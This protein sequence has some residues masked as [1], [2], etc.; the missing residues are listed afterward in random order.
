M[1]AKR[2]S[3]ITL[4]LLIA[5]AV[6]L[7]TSIVL[8]RPACSA[9]AGMQEGLETPCSAVP[10]QDNAQGKAQVQPIE[11]EPELTLVAVTMPAVDSGVS[12]VPAGLAY[13]PAG[14]QLL[15]AM[16]ADAPI[17]WNAA[18]GE[19]VLELEGHSATARTTV[20][21]P[22][23]SLIAGGSDDGTV[24]LWDAETG[25]VL[26]KLDAGFILVNGLAFSPDSRRVA[27]TS[28]IDNTLRVWDVATGELLSNVAL[29]RD[30]NFVAWSPDSAQVAVSSMADD[31]G[32]RVFVV[33]ADSG[34]LV[35][36]LM[37]P[38]SNTAGLSYSPDGTRLISAGFQGQIAQ[39]WDAATG[40]PLLTL[41]GHT[42]PVVFATYNPDGTL[43]ATSAWDGARL[44]DAATGE[45]RLA[46]AAPGGIAR[47]IFSPD[48]VHLATIQLDGKARIYNLQELL[49]Q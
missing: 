10:S 33:D 24:I 16:L 3:R 30:L 29:D 31:E 26:H 21:S 34:E 39:E 23:G 48:G 1:N 36:E 7:S 15:T 42:Q 25:E 28:A 46:L 35:T 14:T 2:W 32:G 41:S 45:E 44:W 18:T 12:P 47:A 8:A 13:N 20:W 17:V 43:I 4:G 49:G 9:E 40:E 11:P 5:V 37:I 27:S 19:Q 22:N 38:G 6:M